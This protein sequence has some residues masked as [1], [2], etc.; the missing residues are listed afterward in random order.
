MTSDFACLPICLMIY[1]LLNKAF[2]TCLTCDFEVGRILFP[3]D[4]PILI[5]RTCKY[6]IFHGQRELR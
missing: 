4:V 3:Q 2:N 6:V 5:P 1:L